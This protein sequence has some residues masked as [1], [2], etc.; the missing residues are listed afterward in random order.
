MFS[1]TGIKMDG[2]LFDINHMIHCRLWA[3]RLTFEDDLK[4]DLASGNPGV[5]SDFYILSSK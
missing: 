5:K 3:S 1:T 2:R 4:P